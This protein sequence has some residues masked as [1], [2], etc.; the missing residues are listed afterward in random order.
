MDDL[1]NA[2]IASVLLNF[3]SRRRDALFFVYLLCGAK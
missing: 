2:T 1:N 3:G